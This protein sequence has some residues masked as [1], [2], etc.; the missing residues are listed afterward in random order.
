METIQYIMTGKMVVSGKTEM[1]VTEQHSLN[2]YAEGM[3]HYLQSNRSV[4]PG[5]GDERFRLKDPIPDTADA[6]HW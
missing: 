2:N 6:A 4:Q 5:Y 3:S 1:S